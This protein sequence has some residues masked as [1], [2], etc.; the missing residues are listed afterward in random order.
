M[1]IKKVI[2][3]LLAAVMIFTLAACTTNAPTPVDEENNGNG[4]TVVDPVPEG[5]TVTLKLYFA[6]QEYIMTGDS[7][8]DSIIQ[9]E[10]EVKLGEKP[11]EEVILEELKKK[12][13]DDSITTVLEKINILS[14]ETA[15]NIAYVNLASENLSGGSLEESLI[16]NQ[17]VFSLTELEEVD[18]VQ[19]LVDGSNRETLMG[20]III[21]EPLQR[22]DVE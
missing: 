1:K 12:P 5:E 16:L 15:E 22:P 8:L 9:V 6:S 4:N 14:V 17:I 13:E 19:I 21:E 18:A 2:L 11:V 20:H 7:N 3:F 10:R